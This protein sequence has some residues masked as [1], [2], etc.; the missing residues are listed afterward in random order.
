MNL[1]APKIMMDELWRG[2]IWQWRPRDCS[3]RVTDGQIDGWTVEHCISLA[4]TALKV[5]KIALIFLYTFLTAHTAHTAGFNIV[6]FS[7]ATEC[8]GKAKGLWRHPPY[9]YWRL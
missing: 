5:D 1:T 3:W 7:S 4:C 9:L 2:Y 8:W 6:R